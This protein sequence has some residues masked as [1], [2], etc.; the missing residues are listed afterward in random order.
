MGR[1]LHPHRVGPGAVPAPAARR[2][3]APLD[4][5]GDPLGD[6]ERLVAGVAPGGLAVRAILAAPSNGGLAWSGASSQPVQAARRD[7]T[8]RIARA[9]DDSGVPEGLKSG[10]ESLSGL[11]MDAVKVHYNSPRPAQLNAIAYAQGSEIHIAPGQE[12]HLAH[13]AWHVVQQK[14]GR[15]AVAK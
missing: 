5:V 8:A 9:K 6:P 11:A 2:G 15:V 14:E 10:I 13:E 4:P 12:Q 1:V 3:R 7:G